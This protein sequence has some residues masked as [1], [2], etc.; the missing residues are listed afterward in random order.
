M[1]LQQGDRVSQYEI[2]SV[3]GQGGMAVV[4]K[5]YHERLDRYVAI[6]MMHQTFLQDTDFRERF[7]REARIV[8]RLEHPNIVPIYDYDEYNGTPFLVMRLVDGMTLKRRSLKK[9]C[10]LAET[11]AILT[12]VASALDYAHS[13]GVLHRDMKPS[14]IILSHD[15]RPYI[16]DFGLARIAETGASTISHDMMLG[17]PY[18]I[19]PE[20]ARGEKTLDHRT[21]IYSLG[22]ILYELIA[23]RVPFMADTPYAIVHGHIY[24][25]PEPPSAYNETLSPE[26]DAVI[27]RALAK[28]PDKRYKTA[29]AMIQAFKLALDHSEVTSPEESIVVQSPVDHRQPPPDDDVI[30]DPRSEDGIRISKS[31][32][33]VR[34]ESS[35]DM[36]RIDF[37]D[38]GQRIGNGVQN[39]TSMIEERIDTELKQRNINLT[40]EERIRRNVEKRLKKRQELAQH[41]MIYLAVNAVLWFIMLSSGHGFPWPIFPTVFWGMGVAGDIHDYYTNYGAGAKKREET[42]EREVEREMERRGNSRVK[43]KTMPVDA[44]H[45]ENLQDDDGQVRVN[46]DGEFTD[47]FVEEQLKGN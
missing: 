18:Y 19:S 45:L 8:A 23:G 3:I 5:A 37:N 39:I 32:R 30:E 29:T 46:E 10:T 24:Q 28:D 31:G 34:L 42:I 43:R 40:E 13:M 9:G 16:T 6:K 14:N 41:I 47:S 12:D 36:G 7:I 2:D 11:A 33:K 27:M 35:F 17:T 26:V 1:I 44:V 20:Q 22:V 38:L 4:Y 15:D 25:D 21:D